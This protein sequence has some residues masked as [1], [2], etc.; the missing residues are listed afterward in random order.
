[1]KH[2]VVVLG[3]GMI[4]TCTAL[5][6]A[7][8]GHAVTLVDRREPGRET[9]YGN[10]GLIQRE[11]VEP[12][13]FPRHLGTLARVAIKRGAD[14]NY[15]FGALAGLARPLA[16]Y[17]AYS[18]PHRHALISQS[19]ARLIEH[20]TLEHAPLIEQA[21]AD[22]LVRRDGYRFVFRHADSLRQ[23]SDKARALEQSHGLRHTVLDPDALAA[24]E[25]AL[26]TRLAGA[27]HWHDTWSVSDPGALVTRYADLF[28]KLGGTFAQGDA[29]SLSPTASG[30]QV[31]TEDGTLDAEHAVVALG[32]WSDTL[33][34]KLGY[35]YPLFIKRGYHRH[36]L[37]GEPPCLA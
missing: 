17:W 9:S 18:Q 23:A 16:R 10:A 21:G 7:L 36:Y 11:A 1:M 35:R 33:L 30:W 3:A 26:R 31:R 37:G 32:P 6:L 28:V 2:S 27:I 29:A 8:R 22:D 20:S 13:A 25:P 14:V 15:H 19:Y 34:R 4:G 24:A 5:Q 12:Y